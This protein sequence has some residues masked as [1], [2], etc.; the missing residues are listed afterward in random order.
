MSRRKTR[1]SLL[2]AV[3]VLAALAAG[4]LF[5]RPAARLGGQIASAD[6]AVHF[7]DIGQGDAELIMLPGGKTLLIDAG[8]N[9]QETRL[10][11]YLQN[12]GVSRIDYLVGTHPHADH[13][14]GMREV[15]DRFPVGRIFMPRVSHT[16]KT[17]IDLL[18]A[19]DAKGL[20]IETARQGKLLFDEN[21]V[22]AEFL[23]PNS[24][25][26]QDLNNY[27]AVLR[28]DYRD[29]SFLFTG[30][31][32]ALSENEML[33]AGGN[34]QADIL[35]AGHHGSST[36]TSQKFLKAVSPSCAVISCGKGNSYGHP[37]AETLK[38]LEKSGVQVFR[39]D[40][41]GTIIMET[42]GKNINIKK[43]R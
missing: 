32:E 18:K 31:A 41:M 35:K 37:H 16:S 23:A 4:F 38:K 5:A 14:G 12:A 22:R 26:Y 30:D 24:D 8:D 20:S 28:L 43:E 3:V 25:A 34:L 21:G 7:I 29:V 27:S 33:A 40:E 2:S 1:I 36:S 9:G 11:S 13:I 19:I 42:D 39:T 6:V 17:Y 15:V 10:L